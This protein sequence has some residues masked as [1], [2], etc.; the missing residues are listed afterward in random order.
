MTLDLDV[1]LVG[2]R[3]RGL[4]VHL[5]DDV[6]IRTVTMRADASADASANSGASGCQWGFSSPQP[7]G[8]G[9]LT[10]RAQMRRERAKHDREMRRPVTP[11]EMP[12]ATSAVVKWRPLSSRGVAKVLVGE[13]R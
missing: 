1:L 2:P 6:A 8:F 9:M 12:G 10:Y 13:C 11:S 3:G 5:F 7:R 4:L